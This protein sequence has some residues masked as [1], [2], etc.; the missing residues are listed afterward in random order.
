MVDPGSV[1]G[2]GVRI[3]RGHGSAGDRVATEDYVS[4][5][6]RI[7]ARMRENAQQY[8]R[9][10]DSD[11]CSR[12]NRHG[13][14]ATVVGKLRAGTVVGGSVLTVRGWRVERTPD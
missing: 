5:Q 13:Q 7:G 8:E 4:P 6:I 11:A 3:D 9:E 10:A 12:V 1:R 14:R 2:E